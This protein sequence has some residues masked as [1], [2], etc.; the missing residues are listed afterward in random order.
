[1]SSIA[2]PPFF[3][4]LF[5]ESFLFSPLFLFCLFELVDKRSSHFQMETEKKKDLRQE[6]RSVD[7]TI[8]FPFQFY[9]CCAF[10][11][12]PSS[13]SNLERSFTLTTI[14]QS[15]SQLKGEK[16]M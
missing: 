2:G 15:I 9:F 1:M 8:S 5:F 11:P 3:L 4:S 16:K 14:N 10:F 6:I 13:R 12:F 7:S